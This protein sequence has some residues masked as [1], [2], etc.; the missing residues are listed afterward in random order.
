MRDEYIEGEVSIPDS[1]S[2]TQALVPVGEP[3]LQDILAMH[4]KELMSLPTRR[5]KAEVVSTH[6]TNMVGV[7]RQATVALGHW[8]RLAE[9]ERVYEEAQCRDVFTWL[10]QQVGGGRDLY[11]RAVERYD[12]WVLLLSHHYPEEWINEA[13]DWQVAELKRAIE[14]TVSLAN[15]TLKNIDRLKEPPQVIQQMR[16]EALDQLHADLGQKL[17]GIRTTPPEEYFAERNESVGQPDPIR[18][19]WTNIR[20]ERRADG[21]MY[22]VGELAIPYR[23][24]TDEDLSALYRQI[25]RT[26]SLGC[27]LKG[28]E[29]VYTLDQLGKELLRRMAET[30]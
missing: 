27:E 8:V 20:Q 16:K 5:A 25:K 9:R 29:R 14:K 2:D 30:L 7:I 15:T 22:L 6:V 18:G 4:E 19:F 12:L 13:E 24:D 21:G 10:T 3:T 17:E 28:S 1:S 26:L 23:M 11:V